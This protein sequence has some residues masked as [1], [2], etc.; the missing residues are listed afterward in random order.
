MS[1]SAPL[2]PPLAAC[3]CLCPMLCCAFGCPFFCHGGGLSCEE[4]KLNLTS[5]HEQGSALLHW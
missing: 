2:P 4:C 1:G 5:L 3:T